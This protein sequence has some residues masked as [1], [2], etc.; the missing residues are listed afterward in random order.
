MYN[1]TQK[2]RNSAIRADIF[3]EVMAAGHKVIL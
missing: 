2:P 3:R 1:P